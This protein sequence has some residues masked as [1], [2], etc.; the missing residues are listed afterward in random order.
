LWPGE[1]RSLLP[2]LYANRPVFLAK[3]LIAYIEETAAHSEGEF[4]CGVEDFSSVWEHMLRK[5][6]PGVEDGWNA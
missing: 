6:L 5:V 3:S 2:T 4:V 1:L